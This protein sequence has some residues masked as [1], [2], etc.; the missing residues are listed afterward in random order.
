MTE[1]RYLMGTGVV[2]RREKVEQGEGGERGMVRKSIQNTSKL[3]R[4]TNIGAP[5]SQRKQNERVR[6][7][8]LEIHTH[9]NQA[10]QV[11]WR[12]SV[13]GKEAKQQHG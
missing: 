7:T 11:R 2:M 9:K 1:R 10:H 4:S 12:G 8:L 6:L 13:Y 5:T 3:Y